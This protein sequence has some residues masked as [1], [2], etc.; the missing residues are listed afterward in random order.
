MI[1]AHLLGSPEQLPSTLQPRL[2]ARRGGINL[3]AHHINNLNNFLI[4]GID[5]AIVRLGGKSY[6]R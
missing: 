5:N 4:I 1:R 3:A 6:E 2:R